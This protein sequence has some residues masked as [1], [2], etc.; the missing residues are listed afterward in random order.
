VNGNAYSN[1]FPF[2]NGAF[3]NIVGP[4]GAGVTLSGILLRGI[5]TCHVGQRNG[6]SGFRTSYK[7]RKL[8]HSGSQL[9]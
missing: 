4:H 1:A 7:C 5:V 3:K 6:R 9:R 8:M 2:K